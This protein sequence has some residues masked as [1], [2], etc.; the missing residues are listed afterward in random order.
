MATAT[1]TGTNVYRLTVDDSNAFAW[2]Q[3]AVT[4]TRPT[5]R[6]Y[7]G[8]IKLPGGSLLVYGGFTKEVWQLIFQDEGRSTG[9]WQS[10]STSDATA[11]GPGAKARL[12]PAG[13]QGP[14]GQLLT[15]AG[16]NDFS[17][18]YNDVFRLVLSG[19]TGTWQEV[20]V[21]G[22]KPAVR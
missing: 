11:Y 15:F 12:N 1:R 16:H 9:Y 21:S 22:T 20:V 19:S 8:A 10:I 17:T 18:H 2:L 14:D 13:V 3:I 4:G 7:H 5:R 6:D